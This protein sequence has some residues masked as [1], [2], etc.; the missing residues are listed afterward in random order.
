MSDNKVV[1]AVLKYGVGQWYSIGLEM[2]F[3]GPQIEAYTFEI[4]SPDSK[5]QAVIER[6]IREYGVKET[7][8]CLFAACERIPQPVIGAVKGYLERESSIMS[9][10]EDVEGG[11]DWFVLLTSL[12]LFVSMFCLAFR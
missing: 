4:P 2:G 6:K 9:Q 7:E 12:A 5:L 1:R 11:Y 3:T 8:K 10:R